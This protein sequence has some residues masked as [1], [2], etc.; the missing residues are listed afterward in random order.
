MLESIEGCSLLEAGLEWGQEPTL[1]DLGSCVQQQ[2]WTP[3]L[4]ASRIQSEGHLQMIGL[5]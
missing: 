2:V 4:Y 3:Q 5:Q 1:R